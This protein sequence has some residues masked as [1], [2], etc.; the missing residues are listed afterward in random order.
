MRYED[1]REII[2]EAKARKPQP[3]PWS[4]RENSASNIRQFS[5]HIK[6]ISNAIRHHSSRKPGWSDSHG[7]V[8]QSHIDK[9]VNDLTNRHAKM[10]ADQKKA[11]TNHRAGNYGANRDHYILNTDF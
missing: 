11:L 3:K 8:K 9:K 2:A 7:D 10:V 5:R 6:D 1:L 4:E